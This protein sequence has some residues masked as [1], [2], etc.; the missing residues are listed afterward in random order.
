MCIAIHSPA[1]SRQLTVDEFNNSLRRNPDGIG[2][3][4]AED[5]E[6]KIIK[7]L[8]RGDLVWNE[9]LKAHKRGLDTLVHF[10]IA[11]KGGVEI[12][13]CH[14]FMHRDDLAYIHNGTLPLIDI[15]DSESDSR[16]FA[17]RVL[18]HLPDNWWDIPD[19]LRMVERFTNGS[20]ICFMNRLGQVFILNESAGHRKD[21]IWFSNYGYVERKKTAIGFSGWGDSYG[22]Y[23]DGW[24]TRQDKNGKKWESKYGYGSVKHTE[25][26]SVE[27]EEPKMELDS[28]E[29]YETDYESLFNSDYPAGFLQF[30]YFICS[31]CATH[32]EYNTKQDQSLIPVFRLDDD[33]DNRLPK[34]CEVCNITIT[35]N[36]PVCKTFG[37]WSRITGCP[38]DDNKENQLTVFDSFVPEDVDIQEYFDSVFNK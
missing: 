28:V 21:G 24:K 14:P 9:Y 17:E 1:D 36:S 3:L 8:T 32:P 35:D 33:E 38:E 30:G 18:D 22:F 26:R 10:R 7:T 27:K 25:K 29:D 34:T 4:Y 23:D 12:E 6:F 15:P 11:T 13:N 37:L 16:L 2:L 31:Y 19:I 20:K 5:G